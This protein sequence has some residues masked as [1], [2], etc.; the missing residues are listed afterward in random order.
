MMKSLVQFIAIGASL[1]SWLAIPAAS[2]DSAPPTRGPV[3]A[4]KIA[5]RLD[6]GRVVVMLSKDEPEDMTMKQ[7]EAIGPEIGP[8]FARFLTG[9]REAPAEWVRKETGQDIPIGD[10]WMVDA[11]RRGWFSASIERHL[12]TSVGCGASGAVVAKVSDSQLP[13]FSKVSEKY[14]AARAL[15]SW[16]PP[17]KPTSVGPAAFSPTPAQRTELER[18]LL[19]EA[20]STSSALLAAE[21]ATTHNRRTLDK[22]SPIYKRLAKGEATLNYD[23]QAFRLTPDRAVRL[24]VRA[25]WHMDGRPVYLLSAWVRVGSSLAI[26]SSDA[27][28]ARFPWFHEFQGDSLDLTRNGQVL[29][30]MDVDRDGFAEVLMLDTGYEGIRLELFRYPTARDGARSVVA[31]FG[32]GC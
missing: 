14:F 6:D 10:R 4:W 26:E 5:Q 1:A 16:T 20:A 3:Y 30:I 24:F 25:R 12:L 8:A 31:T 7:V 19:A 2:Q 21:E 13:V 11:G 17:D 28:A 9:A 22:W 32:A 27:F 15:D 23:V 18:L 29:N